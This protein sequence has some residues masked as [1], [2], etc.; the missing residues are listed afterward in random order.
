MKRLLLLLVII[1]ATYTSC[2]KDDTYSPKTGDSVEV[3]INNWGQPDEK[4]DP[5]PD[6]GGQGLDYYYKTQHK[7][8]VNVKDDIVR[9][10]RD[11]K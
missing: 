9:S 10:I 11:F 3:L 1:S 8:I 7:K 2:K 5:A 6:F 4:I